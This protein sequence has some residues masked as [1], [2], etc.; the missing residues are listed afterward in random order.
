MLQCQSQVYTLCYL[1]EGSFSEL[2]GFKLRIKVRNSLN[3]PVHTINERAGA[4]GGNRLTHGRVAHR[5]L[6]QD[7]GLLASASRASLLKPFSSWRLD[8]MKIIVTTVFPH[9]NLSY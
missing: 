6:A 3:S 5:E 2:Q 8:F 9:F 7:L 4:P 1:E